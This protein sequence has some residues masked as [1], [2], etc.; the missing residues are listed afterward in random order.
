MCY[1]AKPWH[2]PWTP[3]TLRSIRRRTG[4]GRA[5]QYLLLTPLVRLYRMVHWE[6]RERPVRRREVHLIVRFNG[7]SL[8]SGRGWN[9]LL[10]WLG[11]MRQLTWAAW[12][13]GAAPVCL[14]WGTR[15]LQNNGE[16]SLA[17]ETLQM[18]KCSIQHDTAIMPKF[19]LELLRSGRGIMHAAALRDACS[20]TT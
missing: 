2:S 7:K 12:A 4:R 17:L 3:W 8:C 13:P 11:L 18:T 5:L 20:M 15:S 1:R 16:K 14:F 9:L 10:A 6:G 19:N